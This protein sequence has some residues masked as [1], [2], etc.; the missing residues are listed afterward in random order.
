MNENIAGFIFLLMIIEFSF[1]IVFAVGYFIDG[2]GITEWIQSGYKKANKI[3]KIVFTL[4]IITMVVTIVGSYLI[5][6]IIEFIRW[7]VYLCTK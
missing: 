3:G 5:Q 6:I 7:L 4:L 2:D 1:S